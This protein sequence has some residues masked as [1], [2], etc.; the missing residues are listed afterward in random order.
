MTLEIQNANQQ[1]KT[2]RVMRDFYSNLTQYQ[3][4]KL[5]DIYK[6]D[7]ILFNY[8]FPIMYDAYK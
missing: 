7:F 3:T 2:E 1:S 5:Y 8:S 4:Q 6:Y